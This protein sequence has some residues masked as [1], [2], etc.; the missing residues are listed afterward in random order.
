MFC[1]LF[2][3]GTVYI[4]SGFKE[5]PS[6]NLVALTATMYHSLTLRGAKSFLRT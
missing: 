6:F 4:Q 2:S 5:P 3:L 1:F